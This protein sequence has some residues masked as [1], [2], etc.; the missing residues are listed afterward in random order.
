MLIAKPFF[1]QVTGTK[2][3]SLYAPVLF[4]TIVLGQSASLLSAVVTG[5]VGAISTFISML[6]VDK[7]LG[8]RTVFVIGG[9]QMLIS[10][11]LVGAV[12]AFKL[13]DHGGLS[14]PC[15]YLVLVMV[16]VYVSEFGWSCGPPRW[17]VPSEIYPL[18][19]RSAGQ[20]IKVA[21]DF[22]FIFLVA[23]TFLS[24][25]CHLKYGLFFRFFGGWAGIMTIA[26]CLLLPE[27]SRWRRCGGRN[28]WLWRGIVGGDGE[29]EAKSTQIS[30]YILF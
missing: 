10:Q 25:L 19:I 17:L 23:Q 30:Y 18:E 14:K 1:Q 16:C 24:M 29:G 8:R 5:M 21:V 9:L 20:S 12:M 6:M 26:V 22:L 4:R 3:I 7:Q 27:T 13:G 11:V 2:V 15:A 28:H